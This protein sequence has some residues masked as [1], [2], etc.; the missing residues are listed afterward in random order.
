MQRK[1]RQKIVKFAMTVA[2]ERDAPKK[3]WLL[4]IDWALTNYNVSQIF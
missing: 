1:G 2:D 3:Y 4:P